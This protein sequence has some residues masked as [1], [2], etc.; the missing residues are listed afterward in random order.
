[1]RTTQFPALVHYIS[2]SVTVL[3]PERPQV[4]I[5]SAAPKRS[6]YCGTATF[7][8]W[9]GAFSH[10]ASSHSDWLLCG[11]RPHIGHIRSQCRKAD[12][13]AGRRSPDLAV[14]K[15]T[16]GPAK[17]VSPASPH[18]TNPAPGKAARLC[19]VPGPYI[20]IAHS[21][22]AHRAVA[23][24]SRYANPPKSAKLRWASMSWAQRATIA[25]VKAQRPRRCSM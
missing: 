17:A 2:L 19:Q 18:K 1:M 5:L 13:A 8:F 12:G 14:W 16:G 22:R 24:C 20:K 15:G 11:L 6:L 23:V 4:R 9:P 3:R 21:G 7:L 10:P 25:P